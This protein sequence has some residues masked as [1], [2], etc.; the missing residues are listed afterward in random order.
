MYVPDREHGVPELDRV[1]REQARG[2][3]L[4]IHDSQYTPEEYEQRKGWGHS[5]WMETVRVA[6][7]AGVKRL[8]LFHHDPSHSDATIEEIAG[9]AR[10]LFPNTWAAKEGWTIE[11]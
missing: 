3:D 2:A 6:Q 11:I 1:I 4:L 10:L 9:K 8:V 7:D 5:T